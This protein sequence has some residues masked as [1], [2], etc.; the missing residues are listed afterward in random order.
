MQELASSST[1]SDSNAYASS[2]AP[3]YP[4]TQRLHLDHAVMLPVSQPVHH[5][6]P[7]TF[8][9]SNREVSMSHLLQP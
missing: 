5:W 6:K 7:C 4:T 8:Y 2:Q 9:S 1:T 3:L